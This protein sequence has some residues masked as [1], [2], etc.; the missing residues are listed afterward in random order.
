MYRVHQ[1]VFVQF[2]DLRL[3]VWYQGKESYKHVESKNVT[4]YCHSAVKTVLVSLSVQ[5]FLHQTFATDHV[6]CANN[7]ISMLCSRWVNL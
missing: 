7:N 1:I 2:Q 6:L 3:Q 5:S 4:A